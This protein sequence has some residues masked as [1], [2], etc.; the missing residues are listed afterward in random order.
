MRHDFCSHEIQSY[1]N[2][3]IF[4]DLNNKIIIIVTSKMVLD[5]HINI[6]FYLIFSVLSKS[7]CSYIM[8]IMWLVCLVSVSVFGE[9]FVSNPLVLFMNES[10]NMTCFN[11]TM[12]NNSVYTQDYYIMITLHSVQ[13]SDESTIIP[14]TNLKSIIISVDDSEGT[15][16]LLVCLLCAKTSFITVVSFLFERDL[17]TVFLQLS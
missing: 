12:I 14:Y 3:E 4:N 13:M 9:D 10:Q 11:L 1:Y 6:L 15:Q 7:S 16:F 17:I 8:A 5:H 2:Y